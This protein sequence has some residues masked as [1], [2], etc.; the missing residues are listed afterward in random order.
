VEELLEEREI[1]AEEE[2]GK[3]ANCQM[4]KTE[5]GKNSLRKENGGGGGLRGRALIQVWK[6]IHLP[7]MRSL[8]TQDVDGLQWQRFKGT[9]KDSVKQKINKRVAS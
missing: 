8:G 4:Q 5:K 7:R 2:R 9:T 6:D 1:P 3:K